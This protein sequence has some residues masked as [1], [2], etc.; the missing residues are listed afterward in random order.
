LIRQDAFGRL[1]DTSILKLQNMKKIAL[2][3]SMLIV[4]L[5]CNSSNDGDA[6]TR[7]SD[8]KSIQDTGSLSPAY[9][10]TTLNLDPSTATDTTS[11]S[12]S[13]GGANGS[14]TTNQK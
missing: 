3:G 7:A 13:G 6:S 1:I 9:G 8:P 12:Y 4:L 10:D 2:A 11:R 14:G 5:S